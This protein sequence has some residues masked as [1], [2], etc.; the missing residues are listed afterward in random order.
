M[1]K[2]IFLISFFLTIKIHAQI[3]DSSLLI[4]D[5]NFAALSYQKGIS[6]AFDAYLRGCKHTYI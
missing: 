6:A 2:S 4:A 3:H 1:A 5:R